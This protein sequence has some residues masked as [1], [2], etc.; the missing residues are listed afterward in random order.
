ML[1]I[2]V[3]GFARPGKTC[4]VTMRRCS[5]LSL[6]G[7]LL[8]L[9]ASPVSAITFL[10]NQL[11][12]TLH[13]ADSPFWVVG[14]ATTGQDTVVV[15]AGCE[16][17]IS[18][19]SNGILISTYGALFLEGTPSSRITVLPISG[20]TP[21]RLIRS[22]YSYAPQDLVAS[23]VDFYGPGGD[24]S[25]VGIAFPLQSCGNTFQAR[26]TL[27]SCSFNDLDLGFQI[28]FQDNGPTVAP[29]IDDCVFRDCNYGLSLYT[30]GNSS[31][32]FAINRGRSY[33]CRAGVVAS[34]APQTMLEIVDFRAEGSRLGGA[35]L[36]LGMPS[37]VTGGFFLNC[38]YGV[39]GRSVAISDCDFVQDTIAVV[40]EGETSC[41]ASRFTD[42]V[43]RDVECSTLISVTASVDFTGNN[44][45]PAHTAELD[46]I[47]FPANAS[48][49]QDWWDNPS[50][51]I[52]DYSGWL[53]AATGVPLPPQ[54]RFETKSWGAVKALFK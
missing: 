38:Y 15:E 35:G 32:S 34:G 3:A 25:G 43:L 18:T 49:I 14:P 37:T 51:A 16:I 39:V 50:Y 12:D 6:L 13:V 44:W 23:N 33:R 5:V 28:D 52:V 42:S 53:D 7:I 45:G 10:A 31:A 17:R 54:P 9:A 19:T 20:H 2:L 22:E 30:C 46:S 24:P 26:I 29:V 21:A 8:L 36:N 48:F 1:R 41:H 11:P 4:R 27:T 40:A 47:G